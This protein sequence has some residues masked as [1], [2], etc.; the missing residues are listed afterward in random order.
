MSVF[1]SKKLDGLFN[2]FYSLSANVVANLLGYISSKLT[3]D[4]IC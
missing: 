2:I 1:S 4:S 3:F